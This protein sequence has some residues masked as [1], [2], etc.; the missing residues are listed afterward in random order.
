MKWSIIRVFFEFSSSC[1]IFGYSEATKMC[2]TSKFSCKECSVLRGSDMRIHIFL[3]FW[4]VAYFSRVFSLISIHSDKQ[5]K[6]EKKK[7]SRFRE[8]ENLDS[9]FTWFLNLNSSFSSTKEED[10]PFFYMFLIFLLLIII[11]KDPIFQA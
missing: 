8:R 5:K 9:W 6:I 11:F 4:K 1:F 10:I 3:L 7:K 2:L